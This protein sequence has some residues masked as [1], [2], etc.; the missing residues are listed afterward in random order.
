MFRYI[1]I[2]YTSKCLHAFD[3][4]TQIEVCEF[5]KYTIPIKEIKK[6]KKKRKK[7]VIFF[8]SI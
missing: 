4:Y 2:G 8:G 7:E 5:V 1:H 6:E 3:C